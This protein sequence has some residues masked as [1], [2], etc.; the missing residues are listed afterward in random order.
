[1]CVDDDIENETRRLIKYTC[2]MNNMLPLVAVVVVARLI[3]IVIVG[4]AR[5][6]LEVVD[7]RKSAPRR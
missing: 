4:P 1:M 5:G 7:P 3:A 2:S 6:S